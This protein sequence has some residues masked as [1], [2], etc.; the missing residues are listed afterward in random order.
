MTDI[1]LALHIIGLMMGA[2]GGFGSMIAARAAL[3]R[4]PEQAAVL[5]SLGPTLANFSGTGL[6]LMLL[7]GFALVFTK[8][9]GFA[10]LPTMFWIKIVFVTTLTLAALATHATY[11]QVKAGNAAAAGRLAALGPIAGLSSILAVIFA[12]LAFH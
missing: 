4:P 2:G 6:I 3:T 7:T 8:Y 1:L 5:R 9:N 11:G 12:V 10:G